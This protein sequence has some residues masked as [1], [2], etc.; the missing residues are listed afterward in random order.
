MDFHD[1]RIPDH[2]VPT[3]RS[4]IDSVIGIVKDRF[5]IAPGVV[6]KYFMLLSPI[7][8]LNADLHLPPVLVQDEH[9][10]DK[11]RAWKLS[12]RFSKVSFA[13]LLSSSWSYIRSQ[14]GVSWRWS[15]RGL[16]EFVSLG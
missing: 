15:R 1:H 7:H 6:L 11:V 13:N 9:G 2:V 4:D 16:F 8:T 10:P 12:D 14:T 5:P 3:Q